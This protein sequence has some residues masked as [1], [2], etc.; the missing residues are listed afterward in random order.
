[1]NLTLNTAEIRI[2]VPLKEPQLTKVIGFCPYGQQHPSIIYPTPND[3]VG[4]GR[5]GYS[6]IGQIVKIIEIAVSNEGLWF[7]LIPVDPSHWQIHPGLGYRR[8]DTITLEKYEP[9]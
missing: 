8:I 2:R 6:E 7:G 5:L 4:S 1:M 3:G 9:K